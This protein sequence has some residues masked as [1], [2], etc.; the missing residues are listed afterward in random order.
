[1]FFG[2]IKGGIR[3]EELAEL[4]DD[5]CLAYGEDNDDYCNLA[6]DYQSVYEQIQDLTNKANKLLF[7]SL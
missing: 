7:D 4:I 6:A 3:M 1:M 2:L 5:V